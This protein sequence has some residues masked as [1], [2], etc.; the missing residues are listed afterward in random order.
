LDVATRKTKRPEDILK[1]CCAAL[2]ALG[3]KEIPLDH[4]LIAKV[5]EGIIAERTTAPMESGKVVDIAPIVSWIR[6]NLSNPSE[7]EDMRTKTIVLITIATMARPKD[8]T[9]L[10][11]SSI[12]F[13]EDYVKFTFLGIKNDR[14]R[15][16]IQKRVVPASIPEI[17]PVETLKRWL[18]LIGDD[19]DSPLFCKKFNLSAPIARSTISKAIK[20][21]I[22]ESGVKCRP[23]DFRSTLTTIAAKAGMEPYQIMALGG[24]K[25]FQTVC[26]HYIHWNPRRDATNILLGLNELPN[27][28]PSDLLSL[29]ES[30]VFEE[31]KEEE[32]E[33]LNQIQVVIDQ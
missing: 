15:R 12:A 6:S 16:S 4:E 19:P 26:N 8:L 24:W 7:F 10:K 17:C 25:N 29:E 31:E 22:N 27:I 21:V 1:R 3:D 33:V 9:V 32:E 14:R 18:D 5:K 28:P 2:R 13:I 20:K 30:E 11:R 23:K